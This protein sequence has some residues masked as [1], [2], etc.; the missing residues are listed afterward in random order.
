[1]LTSTFSIT[2]WEWFSHIT[3]INI[4][5]QMMFS[6]SAIVMLLVSVFAFSYAKLP[7][8]IASVWLIVNSQITHW[9]SYLARW[10]QE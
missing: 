7:I 5:H 10:L 6:L 8:I 1:M 2:A 3:H 9:R 4:F